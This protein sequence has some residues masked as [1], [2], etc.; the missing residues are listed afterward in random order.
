MENYAREHDVTMADIAAAL[1][2]ETRD[3]GFLM[4]PDPPE[5]ERPA[6]RERAPR[7]PGASFATYRI[8][9]G[10]KHKVSPGAIVGAIANE[11]GLTR[12]DFGNI[13]IRDDFS[14]VELPDDLDKETLSLLRHTR[15]GKHPIDIRK[16]LGAPRARG[17][18]KRN[19]HGGRDNW[20][21]RPSPRVAGRGR[22]S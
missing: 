12:A 10:R 3:G 13:S 17:G 4:A 15:I 9:V 18:A 16:D 14:L 1:A 22:R 2:L 21:K 11:G 6:R 8:A 7:R 20:G 19:A 5:S